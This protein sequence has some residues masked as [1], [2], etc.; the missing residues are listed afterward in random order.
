MPGF[1]LEVSWNGSAFLGEIFSS[2]CRETFFSC[3][4]SEKLQGRLFF[5]VS[6]RGGVFGAGQNKER[7]ARA[8]WEFPVS[9]CR[10]LS[11]VSLLWGE[12]GE[13]LYGFSFTLSN[14][15]LVVF[16]RCEEDVNAPI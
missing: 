16:L 9:Q 6:Q 3:P 1:G 2:P 15:C 11:V 14:D 8:V 12:E 13:D 7:E 4:N 10:P 5:C